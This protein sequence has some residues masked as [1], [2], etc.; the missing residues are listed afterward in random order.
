M[1]NLSVSFILLL[2][3][4]NV[5]IA[6]NFSSPECIRWDPVNEVYLV[7]NV[8]GYILSVDPES[9]ARTEFANAGLTAPKGM[10]VVGDVVY[11]TD[12]TEVE[13]FSLADK[14]QVFH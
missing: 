13:G 9:L 10:V 4:I 1:K 12:L 11:V 3:S 7:S 2:L 14:S 6:Q 8:A 5:S